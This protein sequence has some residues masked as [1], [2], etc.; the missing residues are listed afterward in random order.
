M[1]Q[2]KSEIHRKILDKLFTG[3][4]ERYLGKDIQPIVWQDIFNPFYFFI[5][6]DVVRAIQETIQ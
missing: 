4:A 2:I 5:H 1:K 6:T 3:N